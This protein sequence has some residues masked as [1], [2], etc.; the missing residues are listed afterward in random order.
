MQQTSTH[1]DQTQERWKG[2]NQPKKEGNRKYHDPKK[3]CSTLF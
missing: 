3:T 2:N 1:N